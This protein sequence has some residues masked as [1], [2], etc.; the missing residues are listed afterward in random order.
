MESDDVLL[1]LKEHTLIVLDNN[2]VWCPPQSPIA[3]SLT[4]TETY[5]SDLTL[6]N[7]SQFTYSEPLSLDVINVEIPNGNSNMEYTWSTFPLPWDHIPK[8]YIDLCEKGERDKRAITQIIHIIVD[9]MREISKNIP[10]RAFKYV[11]I[12]LSQK[13][14]AIFEDRDDDDQPIANGYISIYTKLYERAAYKKRPHVKRTIDDAHIK[15]SEV[16]RKKQRNVMSGCSSWAP[17]IIND[18]ENNRLQLKNDDLSLVQINT[19]LEKTY[20][21]QRLFLNNIE[22]PPTV[23]EIKNKWPIL[24]KSVG[25]EWHF[26]KLTSTKLEHFRENIKSK[27]KKI[28]L[29]SQKFKKH[30][31]DLEDPD[32]V[33]QSMKFIANYFNEN[34]STFWIK[35]KVL[36]SITYFISLQ[37]HIN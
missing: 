3:N 19:L 33:Y 10:S 13:Y 27:A 32:T 12:K 5:T 31:V 20:P 36:Y 4:S 9:K 37:I 15:V 11:A 34:L 1:A 14:P 26:N 18:E 7:I 28:C 24:F 30:A 16:N 8:E 21:N 17:E 25:I 6:S 35:L 2:E 29:F 22:T 23:N